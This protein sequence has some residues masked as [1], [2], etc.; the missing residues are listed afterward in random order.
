MTLMT[1]KEK[2]RAALSKE[3]GGKIPAVICYEEIFIRDH[4]SDLTSCPWWYAKESDI[5]KQAKWIEDASAKTGLD[6]FY[7]PKC[8]S[9]E[10]RA[11]I[12][13]SVGRDGVYRLDEEREP[14]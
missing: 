3:G 2:V 4:W 7:L 11:N 14:G 8:L 5:N 13:V 6:W 1:G 9:R 10:D 12:K